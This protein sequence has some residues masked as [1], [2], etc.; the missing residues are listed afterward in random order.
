MNDEFDHFFDA[1]NNDDYFAAGTGPKADLILDHENI[2]R[3]FDGVDN[4]AKQTAKVRDSIFKNVDGVIKVT[5]PK[6]TDTTDKHPDNYFKFKDYH[7]FFGKGNLKQC[8]KKQ[9]KAV[10]ER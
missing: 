7:H 9:V 10:R 3:A 6:G 4:N 8:Q 2:L 5:W 1:L